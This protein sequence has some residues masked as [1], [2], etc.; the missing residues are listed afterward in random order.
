MGIMSDIQVKPNKRSKKRKKQ[1]F[2]TAVIVLAVA[3]LGT[4]AYFWAKSMT[5]EKQAEVEEKPE[6][7]T[8]RQ[9]ANNIKYNPN[10]YSSPEAIRNSL[11]Q[12][13]EAYDK[14]DSREEK[15]EFLR[16]KA[17]FASEHAFY[18]EALEAAMKYEAMSPGVG[19]SQVI[20][21]VAEAKGDKELAVKH[22]KIM[23]DRYDKQSI[24][25]LR[26]V[27]KIEAKIL[28]LG[29]QI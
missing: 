4:G 7:L 28:E 26:E 21:I 29:G 12:F 3:G 22:Y 14:T 18:D 19:T 23:L 11:K 9:Q 24:S 5:D 27:D 25:Y 15:L 6:V 13:D 8:A 20:A 2:L 17:L 1:L 10:N 16:E